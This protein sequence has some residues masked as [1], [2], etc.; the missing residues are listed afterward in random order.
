MCRTLGVRDLGS[1]PDNYVRVLCN[2]GCRL[3]LS[4]QR[5]SFLAF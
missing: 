5:L 3:T 1:V 4:P 2:A